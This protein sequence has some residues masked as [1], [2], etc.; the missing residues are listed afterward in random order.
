MLEEVGRLRELCD[1]V[2]GEADTLA[3]RQPVFGPPQLLVGRVPGELGRYPAVFAVVCQAAY[4]AG[5][6]VEQVEVSGLLAHRLEE[7]GLE[8]WQRQ[9]PVLVGGHAGVL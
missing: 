9:Q 1:R 5:L 4:G 8:D 6:Q 7:R 2:D 3:R